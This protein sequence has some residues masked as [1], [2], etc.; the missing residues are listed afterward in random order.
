MA[1]D[2]IRQ[3]AVAGMFYPGTRSALERAVAECFERAATEAA[4]TG[5]PRAVPGVVVPHA[6]YTYSGKTAAR[7][8][9]AVDVPGRIMVLS[10]N[11]TGL[12]PALSIW[13]PAGAWRTPLGDVPVDAELTDALLEACPLLRADETAHLREHGVEVELPFIQT[14][15]PDARLTAVVLRTQA[16]ETM[17]ALGAAIATVVA[18]CPDPVLVVA[19]SDMN[20]FEDQARTLEKDQLAIDRMLAL[21]PDGLLDTCRRHSISMCGV[22]PTAAMLHALHT[23]GLSRAELLDHCT[24]A[25]VSSDRSR[26]VGYAGLLFE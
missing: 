19:S 18:A 25:D 16:P 21:D 12:G 6:G 5:P 2:T 4:D 13:P 1:A 26:V 17:K 10:P 9:Q 3:P 11:H 23:R 8:F 14:R 7:V 20:H 15:R 22:G 24:S